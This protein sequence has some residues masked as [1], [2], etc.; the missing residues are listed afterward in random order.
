MARNLALACIAAFAALAF[1]SVAAQTY[2]QA[3]DCSPIPGCAQCVPVAYNIKAAAQKFAADRAAK[4]AARAARQAARAAGQ[5]VPAMPAGVPAAGVAG[6][7]TPGA[8]TAGQSVPAAG[9]AGQ[10]GP[11]A[12]IAG[13]MPG[14]AV[15]ARPSIATPTKVTTVTVTR[16]TNVPLMPAATGRNLLKADAAD[17]AETAELLDAADVAQWTA[18]Q[19]AV[20]P[21]CVTCLEGYTLISKSIRGRP[22]MGRCGE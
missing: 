12:G 18:D 20:A 16:V 9:V 11:R 22:S 14:A 8:G 17:S 4:A 15:E 19:T 2:G 1:S 7:Y 3:T 10:Y 21:S 13:S 6:R 5:P